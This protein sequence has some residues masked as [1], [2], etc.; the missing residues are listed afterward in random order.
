[1]I[2]LDLFA[3]LVVVGREAKTDTFVVP[4]RK[5][6]AAAKVAVRR[7]RGDVKVFGLALMPVVGEAEGDA[8][9]L[10]ELARLLGDP[11]S[12]DTPLVKGIASIA[13]RNDVPVEWLGQ[14]R[15]ED[16][17]GSRPLVTSRP[18]DAYWEVLPFPRDSDWPGRRGEPSVVATGELVLQ[19]QPIRFNRVLSAPV[20]IECDVQ[21]EQRAA[22]D[23]SLDLH[24]IP[25]GMAK[26]IVPRPATKFRLIYSNTGEY[27][28]VDRLEIDRNG[29]DG[30]EI[31]WSHAPF[32]LEAGRV[33]HVVLSVDTSGRPTAAV[34]GRSY[35]LPEGLTVPHERFQIQLLGWQPTNR[36]HVRNFV[37]R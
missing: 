21:L 18:A 11:L 31:L 7:I 4:L 24:F 13:A 27:G 19:G 26:D 33:Y 15:A 36:W 6:P 28:S 34:D 17:A 1:M 37:V 35:E 30:D 22:N 5:Y 16:A 32:K 2:V 20:A 10:Q 23:G 12:P 9:T 25:G 8:Q 3:N 29:V 14:K